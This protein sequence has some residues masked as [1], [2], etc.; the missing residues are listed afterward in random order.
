MLRQDAAGRTVAVVFQT[1]DEF[2]A[3]PERVAWDLGLE[4]AALTAVGVFRRATL[5]YFDWETKD[6]RELPVEE[7]VEVVSL[8]GNIARLED[9]LPKVHAHAVLGRR[10]GSARCGHVLSGEVR[11]TLEVVLEESPA[12]LRRRHDPVTGLALVDLRAS[13]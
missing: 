11:P 7:Q 12:H 4:A 3:G 1:G 13:E 6:Y 2:V 8:A 10:D 5:G 9:G